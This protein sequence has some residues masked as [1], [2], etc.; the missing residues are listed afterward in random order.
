MGMFSDAGELLE[1]FS[2]DANTS[3]AEDFMAFVEL[4]AHVMAFPD[5]GVTPRAVA[6]ALM[7]ERKLSPLVFWS[8][9]KRHC[10]PLYEADKET[11]CALGLIMSPDALVTGYS[12]GLAA[13]YIVLDNC[14]SYYEDHP[15]TARLI[16]DRCSRWIERF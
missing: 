1:L 7:G 14:R 8:R 12:L 11:L 10:R 9:I 16:A 3:G 4:T 2:I 13:A 5:L 6:S 15:D